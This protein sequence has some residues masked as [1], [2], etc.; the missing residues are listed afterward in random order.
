MQVMTHLRDVKTI[1]DKTLA[2]IEPMKQAI[3]LLK[4][5]QVKMDDDYL[6]L[7]E[8]NKSQLVDV[9]ER[10]LGPVKE[11]ILPLQNQEAQ[12]IKARL[13]RF[14]IEVQEFRIK[15]SNNC[16]FHVN[17]T[18]PTVVENA[19]ITISNFYDETCEFEKTAK[20]LNNLEGLFDLTRTSYKQLKD[21]RNE[22]VSLKQMWDL[23][24]LIDMQFDSWKRTGWEQ[25]DTDNLANLIKDMQTKQCSP[26]AP[27]NKLIYKY[28]AFV[29]LNDRVKN[30]SIILPLI[31]QL[32]SKFMQDRHWKKLERTTQQ[33]IDHHSPKF[34]FE[35]LVRLHLYKY[36]DEVNEIVEGAQKENKIENNINKVAR[37][38]D[39][40]IFSFNEYKDTYVLGSMEEI[41]E[42]VE[43][44]SMELMGMMAQKEV[45][46]FKENV[47]KW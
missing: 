43:T 36:A 45:E 42:Y 9:S 35:D 24:A 40:Q 5:H 44:Q 22:L 33:T 12:N 39:D 31:A 19:Y 4:K 27:Q 7:L 20:D 47:T 21:C 15:F 13:A 32:H 34:C 16:P 18:S 25:I 37:T 26:T 23:V 3:L 41:I 29:F 6:V 11:A 8:N 28:K 14:S 46:E 17:E 38:W 2:Q 1:K 30:M 10:A